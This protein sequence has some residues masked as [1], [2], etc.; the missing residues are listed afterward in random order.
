MK[1]LHVC[2]GGKAFPLPSWVCHDVQTRRTGA[3]SQEGAQI[4]HVRGLPGRGGSG[5]Q[6]GSRPVRVAE[7]DRCRRHDWTGQGLAPRGGGLWAGTFWKVQEA[8]SCRR[9]GAFSSPVGSGPGTVRETCPAPRRQQ[10]TSTF[11]SLCTDGSLPTWLPWGRP[12][13]CEGVGILV[14]HSGLG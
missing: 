8:S 14:C 1:H 3:G 6:L 13:H 7:G 4:S 5:Q 11:H 9:Q 10:R 2:E 12:C